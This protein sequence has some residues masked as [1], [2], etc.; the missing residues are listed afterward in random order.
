MNR[1]LAFAILCVCVSAGAA[2]FSQR[3]EPTIPVALAGALR[4]PNFQ[5]HLDSDIRVPLTAALSETSSLQSH[6]LA[7]VMDQPGL[8][9]NFGVDLNAAIAGDS[10]AGRRA[11]AAF[12]DSYRTA[13]EDPS[14]MRGILRRLL[15]NL[16]DF[17]L[18]S[19]GEPEYERFK[20]RL[21]F[22]SQL[23]SDAGF[24]STVLGLLHT[25]N[26]L[27]FQ[28]ER[29]VRALEVVAGAQQLEQTSRR[30]RLHDF[31]LRL[32]FETN[33]LA[34][35]FPPGTKVAQN[36]V[37]SYLLEIVRNCLDDPSMHLSV[38]P[39]PDGLG[40]DIVWSTMINGKP[41]E[42]TILQVGNYSP[43]KDPKAAVR[44]RLP[45]LNSHGAPNDNLS[46]VFIRAALIHA[47]LAVDA[48]FLGP[49]EEDIE[50]FYFRTTA[51]TPENARS[52]STND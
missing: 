39:D 43:K 52:Q 2:S 35:P 42:V 26:A 40:E 31:L 24:K 7:I 3:G 8:P 41:A 32:D 21:F 14:F 37:V 11:A 13:L 23:Y 44:V 6:D 34:A 10:E 20:E 9:P 15:E 46:D 33:V 28:R 17:R 29:E 12:S 18:S 36:D 48:R 27:K 25:A 4:H 51:L 16:E 45:W 50:T 1:P 19:R 47:G 38:E 5:R 49:D 22:V 30:D